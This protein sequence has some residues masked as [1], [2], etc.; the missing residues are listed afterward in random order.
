MGRTLKE[1]KDMVKDKLRVLYKTTPVNAHPLVVH[2]RVPGEVQLQIQ[3]AF[4]A[5]DKETPELIN[6]IPMKG[7]IKATL[8]DYAELKAMELESFVGK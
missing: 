8:D 4:L 6:M 7:P 1:Q 3:D 5:L 2:P